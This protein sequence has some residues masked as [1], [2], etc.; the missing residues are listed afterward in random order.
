MPISIDITAPYDDREFFVLLAFYNDDGFVSY[1]DSMSVRVDGVNTSRLV[2]YVNSY[3]GNGSH[4]RYLHG[5][6]KDNKPDTSKFVGAQSF[7]VTLPDVMTTF[8]YDNDKQ[9]AVAERPLSNVQDPNSLYFTGYYGVAGYGPDDWSSALMDSFQMG[10]ST[11]GRTYTT[12][13]AIWTMRVPTLFEFRELMTH[14]YGSSYDNGKEFVG[15][16]HTPDW[17]VWFCTS[18]PWPSNP[19]ILTKVN[20]KNQIAPQELDEPAYFYPIITLQ[21]R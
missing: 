8:C 20:L 3:N 14:V 13:D 21:Y 4:G 16:R 12:P 1:T 6:K 2:Q 7:N 17:D 5:F 19:T 15:G 9:Y 10:L 18:T 11:Q